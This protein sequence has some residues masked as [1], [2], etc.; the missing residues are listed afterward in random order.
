MKRLIFSF[1][2]ILS[3]CVLH[4]TSF[5]QCDEVA[6]SCSIE[7]FPF[8]FN[9]QYYRA[10]L[11]NGEEA[12]M[13]VTFYDGIYYRIIPC[14]ASSEGSP[15]IF[16][17]Y[18]SKNNLLFSNQHSSDQTQSYWDFSFGAT[19]SYKIVAK[20]AKGIGCAAILVGYQEEEDT[21]DLDLLNYG[22]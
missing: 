16:S 2:A 12:K 1:F 20:Y 18:D 15:L 17:I 14:G 5:A 19:S 4:E 10:Q 13:E 21:N 9:G 7:L 6:D 3:L 22:N 8:T 11:L